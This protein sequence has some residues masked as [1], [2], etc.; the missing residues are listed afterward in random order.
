MSVAALTEVVAR[1]GDHLVNGIRD[2]DQLT[3]LAARSTR[4]HRVRLRTARPTLNAH[5]HTKNYGGIAISRL[6]YGGD[7]SVIPGDYEPDTFLFPI[8]AAGATRFRYG[9]SHAHVAAGDT[10][11]IPPYREFR[12]DITADHLQVILAAARPRVES[13]AGGLLGSEGPCRFEPTVATFALPQPVLT[14]IETA[15]VAAGMRGPLNEPRLTLQLEEL[16][17]ESLLLSIPSIMAT[18]TAVGRSGT[19][20]QV[21]EAMHFMLSRIDEPLSMTAVATH[22]GISVRSLQRSF[23]RDI[24]MSPAQW[25]RQQRLEVAYRRLQTDTAEARSVTAVAYSCGFYH[26]GEFSVAFRK[27]FGVSPSAVRPGWRHD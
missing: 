15:A 4:P 14:L 10:V 13:I 24:D 8:T 7:V 2:P 27:R 19:S 16:I 20:A 22:L 23:R 11:V 17:L 6:N 9:G 26:L 1:H 18:S 21:R 25:L 12:S 3:D 5:M